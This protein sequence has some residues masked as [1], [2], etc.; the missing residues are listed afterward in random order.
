[1]EEYNIDPSDVYNMDEKGFMRGVIDKARVIVSRNEHFKGKSYVIQD[2]GREWV[3]VIDCI[4]MEGKLLPPWVIF[5]G[6]Q[7][8][9]EW[10]QRMLSYN[11]GGKIAMTYNGWTDNEIGLEWFKQ[12]FI[13]QTGGNNLKGKYRLL[14][15]DGHASHISSE[16]I[17]EC[18]KHKVILL[19]LPP[20]TTHLLQPLDIGLFGP[21]SIYYK[22]EI[23]IR[24]EYGYNLKVDQMDFLKAYFIA[25]DKA[26]SKENI[27]SA[28][29]KSGL[30]PY[31]P[32]LLIAQLP[33]SSGIGIIQTVLKPITSRPTTAEGGAPIFDLKTPGNSTHIREILK[34]QRLGL[35][36]L[37]LALQKVAKATEQ[38]FAELAT[39]GELNQQLYTASQY[40]KEREGRNGEILRPEEARIY[41]QL[42]LE[43]RSI[44]YHDMLEKEVL[45]EHRRLAPTIFDFKARPKRAMKQWSKATGLITLPIRATASRTLEEVFSSPSKSPSKLP[46]KLPHKAALPSKATKTTNTTILPKITTIPKLSKGIQKRKG[47]QKGKKKA[48]LAIRR[49]IQEIIKA[50][51]LKTTRGGRIII[52]SAKA[53]G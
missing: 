19:C 51:E 9:S 36:D 15:F 1:M 49:R 24:S 6:V 50:P 8:R 12:L 14:I 17:R 16:V 43:K 23:R 25:R 40:K 5:K 21:L 2:R 11:P 45:A 39:L 10:V 37:D 27:I 29:K 4:S 13:P 52:P 48:E 33:Q 41:D 44:W 26:F 3:T 42:S 34:Q 53:K 20:H 47:I 31:D 35:I 22:Q 18:V 32:A 46:S 38:A 7:C 28:F 30:N